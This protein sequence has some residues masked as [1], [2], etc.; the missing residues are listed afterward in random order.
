MAGAGAAGAAPPRLAQLAFLVVAA[1]LIFSKVWSQQFVLW[2]LPLAVLARPR[3]GAFLAWQ[4]AEVCYFVAVLRRAAGRGASRPVFPEGVFVLAATLRLVTVV[5]LCVLVV[6]EILH[7]ERDAVRRTYADDPDGGVL[8]GA[9]RR[10][11]HTGWRPPRTGTE[12]SPSQ[13]PARARRP[14]SSSPVPEAVAD[15]HAEPAQ[16]R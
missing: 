6:R 4:V 11:W 8:D 12:L 2:L 9:P 7:P 5:L 15:R 1:F 13:P 14:G 16:R 10:A 3:W